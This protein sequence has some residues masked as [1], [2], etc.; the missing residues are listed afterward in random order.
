MERW[1][2]LSERAAL[3]QIAIERGRFDALERFAFGKD[4][5]HVGCADTGLRADRFA[6]GELLHERLRRVARSLHGV[7]ISQEDVEALRCEGVPNLHVADVCD[8]DWA[9]ELEGATF[10]ALVVSEVLEHVSNAGLFLTN[11]SRFAQRQDAAAIFT[12]PTPFNPRVLRALVGNYEFV[13]PDHKYWFSYQ[14]VTGLME[15]HGWEITALATYSFDDPRILQPIVE[16]ARGRSSA[17][18]S[19]KWIAGG[20]R[21]VPYRVLARWLQ[22]RSPFFADGLIVQARP[23]A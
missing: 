8:P 11:L 5:L 15:G 12:V 23:T 19:L 4:V 3:P 17:K 16:S 21:E 1:H 14:T 10:N 18:Q 2:L 6:K 9:R 20:L 13:H 7:D 22:R